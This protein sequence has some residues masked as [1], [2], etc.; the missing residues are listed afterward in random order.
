MG[1][2]DIQ[3]Y[4]NFD[5]IGGEYKKSK[6]KYA[7]KEEEIIKIVDDNTKK[8]KKDLEDAMKKYNDKV[9]EITGSDKFKKLEKETIEH[10][11][12]MNKQ[13]LIAKNAF[14]K[15]R[16]DIMKKEDI[17]DRKKNK[18]INELFHKIL[19][20]F[21]SQEEMDQ[22]KNAVSQYVTVVMPKGIES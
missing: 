15:V 20:K 8:E 4:A 19:T 22:F 11:E 3:Q 9:K 14:M 2:F 12:E 5:Q 18:K 6:N 1:D 16:E 13:M 7:K 10:S 21:Y 17:S